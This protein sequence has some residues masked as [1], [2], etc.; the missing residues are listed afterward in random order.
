MAFTCKDCAPESAGWLFDL[1]MGVSRGPCEYCGRVSDCIDW[2]GDSRS[3]GDKPK[4][5]PLDAHRYDSREDE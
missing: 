5:E 1:A 4:G 2:H 3:T